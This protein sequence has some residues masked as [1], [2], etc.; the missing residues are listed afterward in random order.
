[1]G[2]VRL[3]SPAPVP[4]RRRLL[5][6]AALISLLSVAMVGRIAL[7]GPSA[8]SARLAAGCWASHI[9]LTRLVGARLPGLQAP[10]AATSVSAP[11]SC[12]S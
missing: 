8:F 10:A 2:D 5:L 6:F 12:A 3:S 7:A 11:T 4:S 9:L 1:M